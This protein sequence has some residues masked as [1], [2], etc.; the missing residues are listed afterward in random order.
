MKK[1]CILLVLCLLLTGCAPAVAPEEQTPSVSTTVPTTSD[2]F[3]AVTDPTEQTNASS[4]SNE[5]ATPDSQGNQTTKPDSQGGETTKPST[6]STKPTQGSSKDCAKH[7]DDGD[8]GKCDVCGVST[9][10]IVDFYNI[11]DLHGKIAD[12]DT[13]P[14]VDEL[15]TYLKKAK[16]TD[17]HTVFLSTGD[18]WQGSSESNLTQGLLTT[19]WMNHVGFAAMSM[20]NHEYD[21]GED[22]VEK[23]DDLAKFPFLG[24]NIYDRSTNK[25]V[26]YCDSSVMITRGDIQIGIIGAIGDCYSSISKDKVS[27]IY[28]KV[29]NDLTTLVK[30]EATKLRQKGADYIVYLLHDGY[31][32]SGSS[33]V[34]SV[35]SSKLKSYYDVSLSNGYVDLVFEGHTHQRYILKDEYGVYH[36]QNKGDNKGIS[37][38]EVSINTAN[39]NDHVRYS[40]L[41]STG[42]YANMADDPIVE[43]LLNKYDEDVSVGTDVLG[44]NAKARSSSELSQLVAD[45][46]YKKGLELWGDKY[47]IVL[48]GGFMSVRSP[49]TL[50]KGDVTY[51]MLY[52]LLPFDNDLV[53]CSIKGKDLKSRFFETD[54]DRYYIS[55]GDY[56]K[57]VKNNIDPNKTYYI[58]VDSYSSVYA[59]N[60]LTEIVRYEKKY[61]ARDMVA[62]YVKSGGLK[63]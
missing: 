1:L 13:H 16:K 29:G 8:D 20:G 59:P 11:N 21:W 30:N 7:V 14:G 61:Y 19:D 6:Q 22:P 56:G 34:S 28:F 38:V 49:Y 27:D 36:L 46:Y 35:T 40:Q 57:K 4:Q 37:H 47:D 63:K 12:A 26:S 41:V 39:G 2:N 10:V 23:N 5:T 32:Q 50:E 15:T 58:V 53:L 25:R 17:D 52:S 51:G 44:T 24:I 62:D 9:L 45:L 43:D 55:Y 18:M 54:N 3:A 48:G 42:T 33:S 60:R 31:G